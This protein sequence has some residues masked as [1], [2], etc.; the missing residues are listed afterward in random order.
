[1]AAKIFVIKPNWH[2]P[3]RRLGDRRTGDRR[4]EVRFEPSR[5]DRRCGVD[6]RERERIW[7]SYRLARRLRRFLGNSE[8]TIRPDL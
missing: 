6:R 4:T 5:E 1:M 3:D 2:G 7:D 8:T